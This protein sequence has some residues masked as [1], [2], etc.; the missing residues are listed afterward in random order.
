MF[1]VHLKN[2]NFG[3]FKSNFQGNP[4]M[5]AECESYS[6]AEQIKLELEV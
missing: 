3:L 4:T 6:A 2:G 1:I 5:I